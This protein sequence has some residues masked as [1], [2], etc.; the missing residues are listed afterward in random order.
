MARESSPSRFWWM[1]RIWKTTKRGLTGCTR[2]PMHSRATLSRRKPK[3]ASGQ[4]T[5]EIEV[6]YE[7]DAAAGESTQRGVGNI[8]L[9]A[10]YPLYEFVASSGFF[11]TTF[12]YQL[13]SK[14]VFR[15]TRRS[16]RT[17]SWHQ[18]FS[19]TCGSAIISR[20]NP[21]LVIP[22]CSAAVTTA[23]RRSLNPALFS[24]TRS[25]TRNCRCPACNSSFRCSN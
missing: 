4:M 15:S 19:M 9:G 7:R 18:R 2:R 14:L 1:T 25:S 24:V 17:P 23:V 16:A 8:D 11:D 21:S 10:R 5:V 20:C 6:P 22:H 13:L 3:R 12:R